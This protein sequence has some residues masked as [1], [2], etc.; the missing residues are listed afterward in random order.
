MKFDHIGIVTGDMAQGRAMLAA[1]F[2]I[3]SWTREFRDEGIG[4]IVQFGRDQSG[5]CYELV[6]PL[7]DASPVS[8]VLADGVNVIH[9]VAYLT[10]DLQNEA[11]RLRRGGFV[12]IGPARSAAAY[13]GARVQ[14]FASETR[15]L[16]EFIEAPEHV[17]AF[18]D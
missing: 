6:A 17:H 18:V 10:A 16:F 7:G 3:R 1:A 8:R 13:S 12:V 9:H 4:V 15:M 5:V 2:G 14:F 11:K